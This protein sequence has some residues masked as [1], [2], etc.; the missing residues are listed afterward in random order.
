LVK[1]DRSDIA[2]L[3]DGPPDDIRILAKI[4]EE[5]L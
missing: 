5:N 3:P 1:Q 4:D 2:T